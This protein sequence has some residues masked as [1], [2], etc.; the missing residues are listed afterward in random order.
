MT[1]KVV[2]YD[3]KIYFDILFKILKKLTGRQPGKAASK[4]VTWEFVGVLKSVAEFENS[5]DFAL[6]WACI[7]RPTTLSQV[8]PWQSEAILLQIN[9][10]LGLKTHTWIYV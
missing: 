1:V 2:Y 8:K 7:S 10:I 9:L 3:Q 6:I 4:Y 5:L